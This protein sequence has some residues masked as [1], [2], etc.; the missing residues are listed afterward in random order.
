MHIWFVI[1]RR[2]TRSSIINPRSASTAFRRPKDHHF[3][4]QIHHRVSLLV[5]VCGIN[6][7]LSVWLLWRSHA[8]CVCM[9]GQIARYMSKNQRS[10]S[11]PN[12]H[13]SRNNTRAFQRHFEGKTRRGQCHYSRK[14]DQ[15]TCNT[16]RKIQRRER[17]SLQCTDDRANDS[18]V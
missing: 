9:P 12:R 13:S 3:S 10:T 17:N 11:R 6:E 18:S 8:P 5:Y 7:P 16:R 14:S 1:C 15:S 4:S 2:A